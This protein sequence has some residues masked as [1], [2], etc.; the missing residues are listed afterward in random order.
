M[1]QIHEFG[2]QF[3]DKNRHSDT[4]AEAPRPCRGRWCQS[5]AV[6]LEYWLQIQE[7]GSLRPLLGAHDISWPTTQRPVLHGRT[8]SRTL[9]R[10]PTLAPN[11][12]QFSRIGDFSWKNR[13]L[14]LI[15]ISDPA[16][17]IIQRASSL[18]S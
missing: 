9:S 5:L 18:R 8:A 16:S 4:S 17:S 1:T 14:E 15:F 3:R 10:W 13:N 7:F 6:C 2:R 11:Y 12:D